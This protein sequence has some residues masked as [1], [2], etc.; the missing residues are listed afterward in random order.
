MFGEERVDL[1]PDVPTLQ[2]LGYD[3][4]MGAWRGLT[5]PQGTDE[6]RI[7]TLEDGF[8]TVYESDDFQS[9][10]EEQGF[11]LVYRDAEEFGQFMES[12]YERFGQ[13]IDELGLEQ[14]G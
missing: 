1:F 8:T 6:E 11:G 4:T 12:E 10:M 7:A 3:F 5:V 13:I 2:E 14:S 9:F